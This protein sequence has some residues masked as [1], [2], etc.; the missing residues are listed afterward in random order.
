[1]GFDKCVMLLI[2]HYGVIR[3]NFA[4]LKVCFLS[5][6]YSFLTR[7]PLIFF[8]V[9]IVLPIPECHVTRVFSD[10][11]LL[12]SNTC[13]SFLCVLIACFSVLNNIPLSG[14]TTVC[15]FIHLLMAI[16]VPCMFWQLWIKLV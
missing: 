1:M 3:S 8:I 2:N 12:L 4:A 6:A 9:F 15:L 5:S 10:W 13:L 14:C 16:L 11:F 7:L